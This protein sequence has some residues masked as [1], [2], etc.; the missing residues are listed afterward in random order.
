MKLKKETLDSIINTKEYVL[1]IGKRNENEITNIPI[2]RTTVVLN[3]DYHSY[4]FNGAADKKRDFYESIECIVGQAIPVLYIKNERNE[5]KVLIKIASY[6][7]PDKIFYINNKKGLQK[8]G[9]VITETT[10]EDIKNLNLPEV[11]VLIKLFEY[12]NEIQ[13]NGTKIY[14]D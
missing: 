5:D 2:K 12:T 7:K 4:L 14:Y 13:F 3:L 11:P 10:K 1:F 6:L 9:K 8:D